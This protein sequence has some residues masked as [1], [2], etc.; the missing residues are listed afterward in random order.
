MTLSRATRSCANG[1][2]VSDGGTFYSPLQFSGGSCPATGGSCMAASAL[3]GGGVTWSAAITALVYV[4]G[5]A[6]GPIGLM[7]FGVGIDVTHIGALAF[8]VNSSA[9]CTGGNLQG[10]LP[11]L[12]GWSWGP[13][14][15]PRV[16]NVT[17]RDTGAAPGLST[18]DTLL[19]T[20]DSETNRPS[21]LNASVLSG[22]LGVVRFFWIDTPNL[23]ITVTP[24][25]TAAATTAVQ[26]G[27]LRLLISPH[28]G[29][30]SRDL[31]S[32]P[33]VTNVLVNGSWGNSI[34][35]V[36]SPSLDALTTA[37]GDSLV[38]QLA[39]TIG[40]NAVASD[41]RVDY[42][43]DHWTLT[44]ARCKPLP[45][46]DTITCVTVQGTGRDYHFLVWAYGTLIAR[47]GQNAS[48][49][50]PVVTAVAPALVSTD[51]AGTLV[52]T[53][54]EFG[55][56]SVNAVSNV[57]FSTAGSPTAAREVFG[58]LACAV[59]ESHTT[60]TCGLPSVRGSAL[61]IQLSIGGQRTA[62]ASLQTL[63]PVLRSVVLN[64]G[65]TCGSGGGSSMCT[66]GSS[67]NVAA[68]VLQGDNFGP[69][70]ASGLTVTCSPDAVRLCSP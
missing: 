37:G 46:G 62:L 51:Y 57:E 66:R 61:Q 23:I 4:V 47:G 60:I 18:G 16:L 64:A 63:P 21:H 5:N 41:V 30:F 8:G 53:G 32:P 48:Y 34:I 10:A 42:S 50:S 65:A 38:V 22:Y 15:A 52:I 43:N 56:I 1:D 33:S 6:S 59:N 17:A 11:I 2:D 44:A 27:I 54:R 7:S 36:A 68:A 20:Y 35:S 29:I 69:A 31:S 70:G 40:A 67:G 28:D 14:P 49:A 12:V 24:T 58:G 9:R 39:A 19:V 45:A 13:Q 55:S 25:Y 26:I 3:M